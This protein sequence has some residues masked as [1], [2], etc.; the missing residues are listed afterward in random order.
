MLF[1]IWKYE[2]SDEAVLQYLPAIIHSG[3][4]DL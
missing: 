4:E 2:F 1:I 3:R